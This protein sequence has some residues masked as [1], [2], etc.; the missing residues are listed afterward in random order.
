M[1]TKSAIRKM[2]LDDID[3]VYEIESASF[4]SPWTK[5][6]FYH[7]LL[8]NSYAHYLV[9]EKY[10]CLAG[11]C[12]IWI[13]MDDAQITNIAIKSEYRGQ[14]LGEAL[15]RSALELCKEKE[16][17]RLSLE[18][19]VSNHPAQGLY[20]KCGL[21]PGGIRK[22]YYTDNGEDALIMWVTINE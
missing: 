11:Y 13:V 5:E 22:N 15:F 19:R 21:Q 2:Q 20:K 4:T 14:S 18:V 7:E 3:E 9:I 16:A 10:G 1:K 17:R 6:S 8:E 12:G